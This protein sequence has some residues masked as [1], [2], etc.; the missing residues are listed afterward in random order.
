MVNPCTT[1]YTLQ[2]KRAQT[3][4]N[5]FIRSVQYIS[6]KKLRTPLVCMLDGLQSQPRQFG[7]DLVQLSADTL[8]LLEKRPLPFQAA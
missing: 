7:F 3:K 4:E 5:T 8:S 6:V 2:Y 1:T